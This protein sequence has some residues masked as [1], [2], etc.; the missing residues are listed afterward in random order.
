M[1]RTVWIS[2]ALLVACGGKQQD[3]ASQDN[4]APVADAGE[5]VTIEADQVVSL[6]GRASF[7]SNGDS[8]TY[9]WSFD[10]VPE[11]SSV[12][13]ME[14]PFTQNNN[15]NAS[16]TSFQ[17]DAVGTFVVSLEVEDGSTRS[18]ADFVVVTAQVPGTRPVAQAGLD[19]QLEVGA[20][21]TLDGSTSYDTA[22]RTLSYAWSIVEVPEASALTIDSITGA[23]TTT[24][25]WEVDAKGVYI[26]NLVVDNGL[27]ASQPDAVVVTAMAN[28]NTPVANAGEDLEVEDCNWIQLDGS[29]SADPDADAL[30]YFWELQSKP[31]NSVA[32]NDSFS[33]RRIE[34][35]TFWAD[36]AGTYTF[37]LAVS[38]GNNWSIAD[39]MT[40][41]VDERAANTA[42]TVTINPIATVAAGE[43]ECATSGYS[44]ECD[45]CENQAVTIG[46]TVAIVDVDNDPYTVVWELVSGEGSISDAN[47]LVTTLSAESLTTTEPYYCNQN[48][49]V[50]NLTV[51]DCTGEYTQA[52]TTLAAECCGIPS[53]AR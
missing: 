46:D 41:V 20:T 49:F 14:L 38:D 29:N 53:S 36:T 32:T 42:P 33:D 51:T 19:L 39:G 21:V 52:S 30:E 10:R 40:M 16:T 13:S 27:T 8:L 37:S 1:S 47:A 34:S 26:F 5:N 24:P 9:H 45:D 28:D 23:D 15:G 22:G 3:T 31:T 35:P 2:L 12:L 17:P 7:D 18:A 48:Q 6:D 43:A 25:S 50:L 4:A 44:Y 11:G